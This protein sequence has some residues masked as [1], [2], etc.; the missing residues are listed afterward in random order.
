MRE[1]QIENRREIHER[2]YQQYRAEVCNRRGE[3]ES[4][5]GEEERKGLKSLIKRTKDGEII[6]MKT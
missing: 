2:V 3:Q 6:V 4:N 1:A 5:L